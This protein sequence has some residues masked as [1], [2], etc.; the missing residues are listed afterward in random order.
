MSDNELM[1]KVTPESIVRAAV[2]MNTQAADALFISCTAIRAV[3][4]IERIEQQIRKP[5]VTAVQA[6]F[7]QRLRLAGYEKAIPGYG[8]LMRL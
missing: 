1:S 8:R 7:W 3:E 2:E 5:V 6:L 4:V